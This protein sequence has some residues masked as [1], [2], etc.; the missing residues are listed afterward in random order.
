MNANGSRALQSMLPLWLAMPFGFA[1]CS[2]PVYRVTVSESAFAPRQ[3]VVPAGQRVTLLFVRLSEYTDASTVLLHTQGGR[4]S[5]DLPINTAKAIRV[6][7][8][9]GETMRFTGSNP[10]RPGG[11]IVAGP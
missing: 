7:L 5:F 10:E 3:V 11:T 8:Q 4:R 2:E 1:G 9:A 6:Q